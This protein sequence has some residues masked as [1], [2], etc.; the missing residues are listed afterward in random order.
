MAAFSRVGAY[1]WNQGDDGSDA[2][3]VTSDG[4]LQIKGVSSGTTVL[5]KRDYSPN[6]WQI[7][8]NPR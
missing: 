7:L 3:R 4:W 8:H 1:E 6:L 5:E 2:S